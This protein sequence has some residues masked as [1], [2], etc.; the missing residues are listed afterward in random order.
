MSVLCQSAYGIGQF[1]TD[2]YITSFNTVVQCIISSILK[3]FLI[4][5]E[6]NARNQSIIRY[7]EPV[8]Y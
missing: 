2:Q 4:C 6:F 5:C 3:I 1:L 8:Y 7:R